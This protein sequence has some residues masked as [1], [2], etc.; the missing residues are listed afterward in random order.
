M[1]ADRLDS[2]QF[3]NDVCSSLIKASI[4]ISRYLIIALHLYIASFLSTFIAIVK[5]LPYRIRPFLN[6]EFCF[7]LIKIVEPTT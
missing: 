6:K 5:H 1:E 2:F 7:D 3:L 4:T